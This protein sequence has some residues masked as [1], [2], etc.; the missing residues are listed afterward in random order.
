MP[1]RSRVLTSKKDFPIREGVQRLQDVH[2]LPKEFSKQPF[3][4]EQDIARVLCQKEI[5]LLKKYGCWL[6]ALESGEVPITSEAHHHFI[7]A[8]ERPYG[9]NDTVR[10][11][12]D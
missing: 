1:S 8:G 2:S 9:S 12:L 10:E 7:E 4:I 11:E 3:A 6:Q 5:S